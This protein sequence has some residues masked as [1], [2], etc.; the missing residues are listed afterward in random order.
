[1][2]W[3]GNRSPYMHVAKEWDG[4]IEASSP[5]TGTRVPTVIPPCIASCR[6]GFRYLVAEMITNSGGT[7]QTLPMT[8]QHH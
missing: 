1:M 4:R 2:G 5:Q 8:E 3:W 7:E 6:V